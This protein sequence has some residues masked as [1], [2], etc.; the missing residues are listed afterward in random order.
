ME[1]SPPRGSPSRGGIGIVG[2]VILI[3]LLVW[4]FGGGGLHLHD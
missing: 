3:I 1:T 4:L 2:L